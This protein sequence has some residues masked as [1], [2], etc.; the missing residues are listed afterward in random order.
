MTHPSKLHVD[1]NSIFLSFSSHWRM[2]HYSQLEQNSTGIPWIAE[3]PCR[4]T[5]HWTNF[6][7]IPEYA[8]N[9]G[10]LIITIHSLASLMFLKGRI[11]NQVIKIDQMNMKCN[12]GQTAILI[13]LIMLNSLLIA[14]TPIQ[15]LDW[16]HQQ[17]HVV[18]THQ[19]SR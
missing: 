17:F 11:T 9:W 7:I 5:F 8:I 3:L 10:Q 14:P 12:H 1:T 15:S 4:I 13:R 2:N 6:H 18:L 19:R 16:P